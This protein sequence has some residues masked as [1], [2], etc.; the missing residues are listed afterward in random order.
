LQAKPQTQDAIQQAATFFEEEYKLN[1][2][3][4]TTRKP[5]ISILNGI[6]SS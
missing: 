6:T 5:F 2:L 3:I 1:H 4:A